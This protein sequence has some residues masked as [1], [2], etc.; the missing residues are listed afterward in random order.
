MRI[1]ATLAS[2]LVLLSSALGACAQMPG[3][4]TR[5]VGEWR[6]VETVREGRAARVGG[7]ASFTMNLGEDGRVSGD[8]ACNR[9]M[10][11]V[12]F[13][14]AGTLRFSTLSKTRKLCHLEDPTAKALEPG[15][16]G[17]LEGSVNYA[18]EGDRLRVTLNDKTEWVF[19]RQR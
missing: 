4:T 8:A 10:G 18:V 12:A 1:K 17:R 11:E 6:L 19:A 14:A 2:T 7:D 9:W 16:P 5:P 15:F 13:S 3:G